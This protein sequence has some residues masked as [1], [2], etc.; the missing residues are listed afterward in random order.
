MEANGSCFGLAFERNSRTPDL[1]CLSAIGLMLTEHSLHMLRSWVKGHTVRCSIHVTFSDKAK[2]L[3]KV[4]GVWMVEVCM[5]KA[6][7]K[8]KNR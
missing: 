5:K 2:R 6:C 4:P 8:K 7:T 1:F 3:R